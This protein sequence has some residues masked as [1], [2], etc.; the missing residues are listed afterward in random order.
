[1]KIG[2]LEGTPE[3]I[4]DFCQNNGLKIEEYIEKPERPIGKYLF[5]GPSCLYLISIIVLTS[6]PILAYGLRTFIFL[7]GCCCS[8]WV[9]VNV[10]IRFKNSWATS[11][12]VFFGIAFMLVALGA[13]SPTELFEK[14]KDIK[15]K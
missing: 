10:Q 14:T 1:M 11:F 12:I 5:I 2:E 9:G 7:F 13:I 8:L 3:E 4:R 15:P 6:G